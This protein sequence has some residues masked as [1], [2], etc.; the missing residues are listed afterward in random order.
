M[1]ARLGRGVSLQGASENLTWCAPTCVPRARI[2]KYSPAIFCNAGRAGAEPKTLL[3]GESW[4]GFIVAKVTA[5]YP[6][7]CLHR[8]D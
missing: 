5:I 2:I 1:K 3:L 7:V 6:V 8:F 4:M